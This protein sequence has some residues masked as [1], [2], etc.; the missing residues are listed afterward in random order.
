MLAM[1][2]CA[3]IGKTGRHM[4]SGNNNGTSISYWCDSN[5]ASTRRL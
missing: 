4:D 3:G 1:S 5:L 2:S